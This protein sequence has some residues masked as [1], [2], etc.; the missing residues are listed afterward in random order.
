MECCVAL[1][2]VTPWQC[3]LEQEV[4]IS[5]FLKYSDSCISILLVLQ[6]EVIHF[7]HFKIM[8]LKYYSGNGSYASPD[9]Q[10]GA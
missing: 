9:S 6:S 7:M 1:C 8:F 5:Q 4:H 2:T 10:V 3:L